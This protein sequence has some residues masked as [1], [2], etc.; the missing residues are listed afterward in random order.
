VNYIM[1]REDGLFT[2]YTVKGE[3]DVTMFYAR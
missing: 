2:Y 1:G 3:L